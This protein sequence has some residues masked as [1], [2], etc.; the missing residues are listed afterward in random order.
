MYTTKNLHYSI[1]I[2]Q[3]FFEFKIL[4]ATDSH[5]IVQYHQLSLFL[6]QIEQ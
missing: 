1:I 6:N 5:N 4:I 3:L 2:I